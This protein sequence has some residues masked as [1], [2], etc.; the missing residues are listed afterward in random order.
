[1]FLETLAVLAMKGKWYDT[2][3]CKELVKI[4]SQRGG[5]V[6]ERAMILVGLENSVIYQIG[7]S[8]SLAQGSSVPIG[9]HHANHWWLNTSNHLIEKWNQ[10]EITGN[11]GFLSYP[12]IYLF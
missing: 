8:L 10:E 1:M 11:C 3:L 6:D 7:Q 4:R 9:P 12:L 5:R 2:W